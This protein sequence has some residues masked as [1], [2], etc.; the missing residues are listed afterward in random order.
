MAKPHA[1]S[2][3]KEIRE[4]CKSIGL[5]ISHRVSGKSKPYNK[6]D[7]IGLLKVV[8]GWN[9]VHDQLL[10]PR[11]DAKKRN[12]YT[13]RI[14]KKERLRGMSKENRIPRYLLDNA[15]TDTLKYWVDIH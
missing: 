12:R 2:S 9:P 10:K 15:T 4:Y 14:Q 6:A 5:R 8:H 13:R 1:K 11:A 3:L 7:L